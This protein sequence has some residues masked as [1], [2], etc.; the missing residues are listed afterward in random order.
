MIRSFAWSKTIGMFRIEPEVVTAVL[1]CETPT[2]G[3]DPCPKAPII[4]VDEGAGVAKFIHHA[5]IDCVG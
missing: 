5:K 3:N 4:T 1:E 2:F